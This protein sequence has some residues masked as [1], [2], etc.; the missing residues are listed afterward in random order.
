MGVNLWVLL[1]FF[2]W[3]VSI[4]RGRAGRSATAEEGGGQAD[5]RRGKRK[6]KE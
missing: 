4:S 2:G 1:S 5:T 3:E 6:E